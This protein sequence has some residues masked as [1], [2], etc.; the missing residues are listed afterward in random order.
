[1]GIVQ[2]LSVGSRRIS[3]IGWKKKEHRMA[4]WIV[5][6]SCFFRRDDK[7]NGKHVLKEDMVLEMRYKGRN[8]KAGDRVLKSLK[9]TWSGDGKNEFEE[10]ERYCLGT[11]RRNTVDE[12]YI[13]TIDLEDNY[14]NILGLKFQRS[15]LFKDRYLMG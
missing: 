4:M 5:T 14:L 13:D 2:V 8:L 3:R 10:E 6:F 7:R 1:M 11:N 12:Q 15:S 9:L